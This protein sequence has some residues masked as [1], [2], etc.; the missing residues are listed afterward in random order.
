MDS[1]TIIPEISFQ[2]S[3]VG[4][5]LDSTFRQY[6]RLFS[7]WVPFF[8]VVMLPFLILQA[9]ILHGTTSTLTSFVNAIQPN[10]SIQ[11]TTQFAGQI[12]WEEFAAVILTILQYFVFVP[13]GTAGVV[14]VL[15]I[16]LTEHRIITLREGL[17]HALRRLPAMMLPILI[18]GALFVGGFIAISMVYGILT[19]GFVFTHLPAWLTATFVI[20]VSV[21]IMCVAIYFVIRLSFLSATASNER[22]TGWR[23]ISRSWV[24]TRANFWRA[25]LLVVTITVITGVLSS[26]LSLLVT[27]TLGKQ[28]LVLG[29]AIISVIQFFTLPLSY[30]A[31]ANLYI[32]LRIRTD[33]L[34]FSQ[35]MTTPKPRSESREA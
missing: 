21:A 1:N 3:T 28:H 6:R 17:G 26:G 25:L 20:L 35:W 8:A 29:L 27:Y 22:T 4:D 32:D 5:M 30:F 12:A 15:W 31:R 19:V 7:Y 9:L 24:L 13:L 34:D 33:A 18:R 16:R 11:N 14:R 2:P 23:P 10:S